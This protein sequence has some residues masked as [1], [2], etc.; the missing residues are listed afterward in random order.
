MH[1]LI[2]GATGL[3]GKEI[4]KCCHEKN[5]TVNYLTTSKDKL[6]Q[7]DNYR[8]FYWNPS[9]GEI[10]L[11]C[12][13]G[14][15][16]IINLAGASLSK[17]WT[18]AYKKEIIDSRVNSI[19]LLKKALNEVDHHVAS[20]VTASAIGI[21]PS[22]YDNYYEEDESMVDAS[23]L[24]KVVKQWEEEADTLSGNIIS[25]AKV[26][27]GLVLT[28]KGGAL[29]QIA[30]AVKFYAGTAFGD[31]KQWQSWIHIKDLV[32]L[33]MF[34]V[35]NRLNGIYNGVAPNPVSNK[36]LVK[37]IATVLK[38]P[39]ILPN[40]PESLMKIVLGEMAYVLY[41]SQRVSS[42]KIEESGFN[43]NYPN[44]TIALKEIYET[45]KSRLQ[46]DFQF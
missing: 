38:K 28:K 27:I 37:E 17:R 33:F 26:R 40:I 35:E 4:V 30:G 19:Q 31:G 11:K 15:H 32:R 10:D 8:G 25:L 2:T 36:K 45:K 16:A 12:L 6:T 23:F 9:S 3:I 42:K 44:I 39:L 34:V 1:I 43:F 13:S 21:Y 29:P 24:G 20:F 41:A 22:S 18:T 7:E 14:V 5:F 46:R